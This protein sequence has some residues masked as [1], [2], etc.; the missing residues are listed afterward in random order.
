[1]ACVQEALVHFKP[2]RDDPEAH[3]YFD[4]ISDHA[5]RAIAIAECWLDGSALDAG[6]VDMHQGH[7]HL[8][9]ASCAS[10]LVAGVARLAYPSVRPSDSGPSLFVEAV[11]DATVELYRC[12]LVDAGS[13]LIALI[14]PELERYFA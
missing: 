2:N 8:G 1:M 13:R 6:W 5:K 3:C 7:S 10:K 9:M 12:D 4:D 14:R 11:A